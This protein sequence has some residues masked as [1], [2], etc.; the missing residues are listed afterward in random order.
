MKL[1]E[2]MD[3]CHG[4]ELMEIM[5]KTGLTLSNMMNFRCFQIS[6]TKNLNFDEYEGR[7]SLKVEN[8]VGNG[9]IAPQEQFLLFS[10]CFQKYCTAETLK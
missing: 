2:S 5:L 10:L 4:H 9:E 3:R 1:I 6:Q 7:F 8:T